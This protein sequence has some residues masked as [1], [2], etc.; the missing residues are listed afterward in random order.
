MVQSGPTAPLHWVKGLGRI[1][2]RVFVADIPSQPTVAV[3]ASKTDADQMQTHKAPLF[4]HGQTATES[5]LWTWD[6][7]NGHGTL[8]LTF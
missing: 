5:Q 6:H 8:H 1:R 2:S 7:A 4:H 3:T